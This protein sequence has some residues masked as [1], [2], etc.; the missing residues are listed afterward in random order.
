LAT[1]YVCPRSLVVEVLGDGK[2]IDDPV[3]DTRFVGLALFDLD[4]TL[5]DRESAFARWAQVFISEHGLPE[6]A[7]PF[8]ESADQDGTAPRQIF[9]EQVRSEFGISCDVEALLA[10]YYVNYPACYTAGPEI[11][12]G[13]RQ[14]R[15][16]GW[17]VAVVTNGGPAQLA[18]LDAT[19]LI[20][21]FDAICVSEMVGA[22]K[23]DPAILSWRQIC[24]SDRLRAG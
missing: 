9:F 1:Q 14:V 5:L 23:P 17:R 21:E 16:R 8:I 4:N 24:A 20:G 12:R 2:N 11:V 18:K 19:N 15:D 6:E 10:H 22:K 7:S 3:C 13:I